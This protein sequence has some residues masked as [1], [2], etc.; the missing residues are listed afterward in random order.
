MND[1]RKYYDVLKRQT[2]SGLQLLPHTLNHNRLQRTLKS[3]NGIS[4]TFQRLWVCLSRPK[5]FI[6]VHV[7]F[8]ALP[9]STA[10]A[11]ISRPPEM[12][13]WNLRGKQFARVSSPPRSEMEVNDAA[14]VQP[15]SI[16][17]RGPMYLAAEADVP[18]Q[19]IEEFVGGIQRGFDNLGLD[20]PRDLPAVL[21]GN[22]QGDIAIMVAELF[23]KGMLN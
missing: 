15:S 7:Y 12:G 18:S 4:L 9:H 6:L 11:E 13:S 17:S 20:I 22:A 8:Q 16:K 21:R 23:S 19:A 14:S 5:C 2:L 10:W 1:I 3:C